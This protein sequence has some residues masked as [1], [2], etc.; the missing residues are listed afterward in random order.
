MEELLEMS[1]KEIDRRKFSKS[2]GKESNQVVP[3]WL[4]TISRPGRPCYLMS[5]ATTF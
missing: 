1:K 4:L 3:T 5:A 2:H